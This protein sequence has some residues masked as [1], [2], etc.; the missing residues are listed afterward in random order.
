MTNEEVL[1]II[2]RIIGDVNFWG[3]TIRDEENAKN[4]E[5][6]AYVA[7]KMAE[8]LVDVYSQ[9]KGRYEGS[10]KPLFNEAKKA[11]IK[12]Q[13]TIPY[14]E[15]FAGSLS[16][17]QWGTYCYYANDSHLTSLNVSINDDPEITVTDSKGKKYIFSYYK[18]VDVCNPKKEAE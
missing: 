5:M 17:E 11:L 10:S 16:P 3:E 1:K 18:K 4:I 15:D 7:T 2:E 12:I 9:T 6:Y 14:M 8:R 13:E